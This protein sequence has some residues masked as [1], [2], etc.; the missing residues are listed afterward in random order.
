MRR[1]M[2]KADTSS[3]RATDAARPLVLSGAVCCG[4]ASSAADVAFALL[5]RPADKTAWWL[6]RQSAQVVDAAEHVEGQGLRVSEQHK[7]GFAQPSTRTSF[8]MY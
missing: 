6:P 8:C 7:L 1:D 4:V 3:G 5:G 2:R